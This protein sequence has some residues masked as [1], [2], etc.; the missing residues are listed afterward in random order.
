MLYELHT[1]TDKILLMNI[2]PNMR[3]NGI[4]AFNSK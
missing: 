4:Y 3:K 2:L 1:M